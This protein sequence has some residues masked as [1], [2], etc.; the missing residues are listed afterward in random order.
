MKNEKLI[1][2]IETVTLKRKLSKTAYYATIDDG[3]YVDE[4]IILLN[5]DGNR[6]GGIYYM[7]PCDIHITVLPQYRGQHYMSKFLATG[8]MNKVWPYLK[9][10]TIA[11]CEGEDDYKKKLHL[12]KLCGLKLSYESAWDI[13]DE[14]S[15]DAMDSTVYKCINKFHSALNRSEKNPDEIL[16]ECIDSLLNNKNYTLK[17]IGRA[18]YLMYSDIRFDHRRKFNRYNMYNI[19]EAHKHIQRLRGDDC[20]ALESFNPCG[21]CHGTGKRATSDR[22]CGFCHGTGHHWIYNK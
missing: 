1:E 8:I 22:D 5:E 10:V 9:Q 17:E 19:D 12:I 7:G 3:T 18:L 13:E 6:V 21:H 2:I 15:W 14:L 11:N 4:F 16:I 20:S